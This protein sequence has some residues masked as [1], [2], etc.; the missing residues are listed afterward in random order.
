MKFPVRR[1]SLLCI[2]VSRAVEID[3]DKFYNIQHF[4]WI[5]QYDFQVVLYLTIILFR[6][7][8]RVN[9]EMCLCLRT[10]EK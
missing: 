10:S 6:S 2:V 5:K 9:S 1:R 3:H 7:D 4:E 8:N